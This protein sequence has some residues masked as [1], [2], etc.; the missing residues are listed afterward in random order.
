MD[1]AHSN[2]TLSFDWHTNIKDIWKKSKIFFKKPKEI[3]GYGKI[4][5]DPVKGRHT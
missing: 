1:H 2:E 3:K 5:K 4:L